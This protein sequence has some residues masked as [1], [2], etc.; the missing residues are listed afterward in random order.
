MDLD[1]IVSLSIGI[2]WLI[3]AFV[4]YPRGGGTGDPKSRFA[5]PLILVV[6]LTLIWFGEALG[7]YTGST[8]RGSITRRSPGCLVKL[9][10]WVLL[11]GA[12]GYWIY[13]VIAFGR[14]GAST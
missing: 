10:G 2:V 13:S 9:F 11:T 14:P 3:V 4:M 8:G 1:R 6:A 5:I 12:L 7:D